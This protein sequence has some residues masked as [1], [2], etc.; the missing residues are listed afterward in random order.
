MGMFR[1][2]IINSL[3]P[4]WDPMLRLRIDLERRLDEDVDFIT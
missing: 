3:E 2:M 1:Y 4:N